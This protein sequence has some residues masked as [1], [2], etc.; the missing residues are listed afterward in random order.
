[1]GVDL[2]KPILIDIDGKTILDVY[3]MYDTEGNYRVYLDSEAKR[4]GRDVIPAEIIDEN[5]ADG[6]CR[7]KR[8]LQYGK[9]RR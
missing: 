4:V 9:S 1:M 3:K 5:F 8:N 7:R 6:R 2:D